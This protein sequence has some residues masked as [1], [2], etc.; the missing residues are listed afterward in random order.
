MPGNNS[1]NNC[2]VFLV[3]VSNKHT[4]RRRTSTSLVIGKPTISTVECRCLAVF[5]MKGFVKIAWCFE[6]NKG[7]FFFSTSA[8]GVV[9]LCC[10]FLQTFQMPLPTYRDALRLLIGVRR[11]ASLRRKM[12]LKWKRNIAKSQAHDYLHWCIDLQN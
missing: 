12:K 10:V 8:I 1:C 11:K 4:L 6:G 7:S 2:S 5:N 3:H 9:C